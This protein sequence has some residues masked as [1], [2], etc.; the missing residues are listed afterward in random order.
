MLKYII[1][2][3]VNWPLYFA[4]KMKADVLKDPY[5]LLWHEDA[6]LTEH[7]KQEGYLDDSA[8]TGTVHV[9]R[10]AHGEDNI[11]NVL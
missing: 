4:L 8:H 5:T 11:R 10:S 9:H 6:V 7:T 2:I 1:S 3:L